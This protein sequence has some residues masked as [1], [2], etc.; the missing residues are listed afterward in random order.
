MTPTSTFLSVYAALRFTSGQKSPGVITPLIKAFLLIVIVAIYAPVVFAIWLYR[1]LGIAINR[2]PVR[3]TTHRGYP[4]RFTD[5]INDLQE[6][7]K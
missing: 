5:H 3:P 7:M 1:K 2:E 4:R 6:E